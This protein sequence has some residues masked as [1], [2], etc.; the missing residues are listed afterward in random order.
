[1]RDMTANAETAVVIAGAGPTG[2]VLACELARRGQAVRIVE[3]SPVPGLGSRGKGLQPR[4]LEVLDDLGVIERVL[5]RGTPYP[6]MRVHFGP[7]SMRWDMM[8]RAEQTEQVPYPNAWMLAQ[9]DTEALLRTRLGELG[10]RVEFGCALLAFEQDA[11]G[12]KLTLQRG[13]ELEQVRARYLVG[14]DGGHSLVR[15]ALGLAL[16]G[17]TLDQPSALVGDLVIEGL[18]RA[19]WHVWPRARGGALMLCPLPGG[20]TFQLFAQRKA[21]A[22][23]PS[24][25][26]PAVQ[27]LLRRALG[28]SRLKV[29]AA[30]WLSHYRPQARMVERYRVGRV[31]LAGDAAHVHPPTG[32]QGLNIGVQ[33]AHNLGWKLD[34]VLAGAPDSLL[35]SY[36]DE[37]LPVAQ[38]VLQLSSA[39]YQRGAKQRRGD[40]TKQLGTHYRTSVLS[41][42]VDVA[43]GVRLRAGDRAP[44]GLTSAGRLFDLFRG[45]HFTVLAFG[46]EAARAQ[47]R[48]PRVR[49]YQLGAASG[50]AE[51][52]RDVDGRIA[53]AYQ[54]GRN[55]V[56]VVRPDG[57]LARRSDAPHAFML[58]AH[59]ARD[60]RSPERGLTSNDGNVAGFGEQVRAWRGAR[61]T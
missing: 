21:G 37:R 36:Q 20:E 34:A 19:Y 53:K 27:A 18:D 16:H 29:H 60:T 47:L 2:L 10:V 8:E 39:L 52:L 1:M 49:T 5:A 41:D 11:E 22:P 24:L 42:E 13:D 32:G 54:A 33:D 48:D 12:V 15:R 56:I 3:Q 7:L 46:P 35:N 4:T 61:R 38:G 6:R 25:T 26:L 40:Q 14:A 50:G 9:A 45:T 55:S 28:M 30:S 57:Y 43:P 51:T 59:L 44:D 31:F 17:H 58:D 23:P